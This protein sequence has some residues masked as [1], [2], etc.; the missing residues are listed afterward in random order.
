M[1]GKA[2]NDYSD[3]IG[4]ALIPFFEYIVA[5]LVDPEIVLGINGFVFG[6]VLPLYAVGIY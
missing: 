3:R 2:D 6:L 5:E 1:T 4:I